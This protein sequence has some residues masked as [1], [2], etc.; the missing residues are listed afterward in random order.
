MSIKKKNNIYY[1]F[2]NKCKSMSSLDNYIK[3]PKKVNSF[4][5]FE[6]LILNGSVNFLSYGTY[7]ARN[8]NT[9]RIQRQRAIKN[10]Y[11]NYK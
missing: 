8:P 3:E 10:H 7:L 5:D 9:T 1:Y 11:I 2:M 6:N 4:N